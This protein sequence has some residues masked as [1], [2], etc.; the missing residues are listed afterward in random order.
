M[1]DIIKFLDSVPVTSLIAAFVFEAGITCVVPGHRYS[2]KCAWG[3][4]LIVWGLAGFMR[5]L[6]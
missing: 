1:D 3:Y 5:M 2:Q 4:W 6:H